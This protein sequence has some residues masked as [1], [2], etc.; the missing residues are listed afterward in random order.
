M[1]NYQRCVLEI[2]SVESGRAF[3][4]QPWTWSIGD[5]VTSIL[6]SNRLGTTV[7]QA[8]HSAIQTSAQVWV[9]SRSFRSDFHLRTSSADTRWLVS[10]WSPAFI[11]W[12]YFVATLLSAVHINSYCFLLLS[13]VLMIPQDC[14]YFI[15][16]IYLFI[17]VNS[18]TPIIKVLLT[19]FCLNV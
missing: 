3:G 12:L 5:P 7:C 10:Q 14:K 4:Q 19:A 1:L 18:S 2:D 6:Q 17:T 9:R 8:D 16:I 13:K 15:W 11:S